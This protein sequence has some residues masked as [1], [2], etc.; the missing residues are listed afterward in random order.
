MVGLGNP[1]PRYRDTRHNIGFMVIETLGARWGCPLREGRGEFFAAEARHGGTEVVLLAPTTYMN[2]SGSAVQEVA[3]ERGI[4]PD[5]ILVITDDFAL[6][7][8]AIRLRRRGSDG[9]HN[10]LAS[11]IVH[12]GSAEFPRLRCGIGSTE[13][14]AGE[15]PA[16]FVLSP[17]APEERA[18]VTAMIG[19]AADATESFIHSGIDRTMT[20]YNRTT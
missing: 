4:G 5:R 2:N 3:G 6:P 7:L 12:L 14:F 11:V 9:G 19:S 13:P 20:Q 1:G 18:A 17:F 10:G 16:A 15:D 8:G